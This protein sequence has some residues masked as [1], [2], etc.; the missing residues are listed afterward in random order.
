MRDSSGR[1]R[2]PG[3]IRR[4]DAALED[5]V[6]AERPSGRPGLA[7]PCW[8]AEQTGRRCER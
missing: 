4:S 1:I 5:Q 6:V 8:L 2:I 3:V 7:Q